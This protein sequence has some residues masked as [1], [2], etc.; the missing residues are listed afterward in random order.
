MREVKIGNIFSYRGTNYQITTITIIVGGLVMGGGVWL[1]LIDV[2]KGEEVS[3]PLGL[4]YLDQLERAG[5]VQ[6]R[7]Q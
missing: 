7:T 3:E 6:W 4:A 2:G 5:K 1:G